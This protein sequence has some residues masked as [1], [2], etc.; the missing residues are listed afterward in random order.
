MIILGL[1]GGIGSG[2]SL[3]ASILA[4]TGAPVY[5]ADDRARMLMNSDPRLIESIKELLGEEA[6][7][8]DHTLNRAF[9]GSQ[10]FGNPEKLAGLNSIV[11][12]ATG[13]D[14]YDWVEKCKTE[15]HE[16]VVKEAA[17]LFESGAYLAC[18][19]VAT[20]YA[21][22]SVRVE[23]VM[24]RDGISR[25]EVQARMDRQWSE[26]KKIRRADWLIVNDGNHVLIPQVLEMRRTLLRGT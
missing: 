15:N 3:V 16:L 22:G 20:V 5:Y 23:R 14:F 6:Y 24:Q 19:K 9:V 8:D 2:K 13:K 11:H 18:D 12:P 7:F 10:V 26:W 17:I 25:L 1:T 4:K 21:P